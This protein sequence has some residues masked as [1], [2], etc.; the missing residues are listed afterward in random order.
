MSFVLI[1]I[2][3]LIAYYYHHIGKRKNKPHINLSNERKVEVHHKHA[4]QKEPEYVWCNRNI[5]K[6]LTFA[7]NHWKPAHRRLIHDKD[8]RVQRANGSFYVSVQYVFF[9]RTNPHYKDMI[10]CRIGGNVPEHCGLLARYR[11]KEP[12]QGCGVLEMK[13][14]VPNIALTTFDPSIFT[15]DKTYDRY[16]KY[17]WWFWKRGKL[18]LWFPRTHK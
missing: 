1:H 7:A 11:Y 17:R 13:V 6:A 14:P 18:C 10:Q 12:V 16:W 3:H 2:S 4:K 8:K 9:F 15:F 5:T